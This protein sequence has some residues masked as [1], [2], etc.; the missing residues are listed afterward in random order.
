MLK[1]GIT[2]IAKI[3]FRRIVNAINAVEDHDGRQPIPNAVAD[4]RK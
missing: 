4:H 1:S 3:I 2:G